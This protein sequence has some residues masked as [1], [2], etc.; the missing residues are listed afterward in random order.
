VNDDDTVSVHVVKLGPVQGETTVVEDGIAPGERVV[1]DGADKLRDGAKIEPVTQEERAAQAAPHA[2]GKG[3]G[4][5]ARH[6]DKAAA[7][8]A[9]PSGSAPNPSPAA[10]PPGNTTGSPPAPASA[11]QPAK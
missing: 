8:G 1:T 9:S 7:S 6:G 11:T 2:A 4:A 5:R 10:P 3:N